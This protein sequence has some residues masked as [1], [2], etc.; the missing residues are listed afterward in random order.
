MIDKKNM[1]LTERQVLV[2]KLKKKGMSQA[3]IARKLKTT[4]G[5]ICTTEKL[6]LKNVEK[7]K[8]TLK[9][10]RTIESPVNLTIPEG[11]DLYDVPEMIFDIADKKQIKTTLDEAA[12]IVKLK[13]EAA[14]RLR[15]RLAIDNIDLSVDEHGNL[16]IL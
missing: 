12:I 10:Y 3:E 15:G 5:N 4:R 13:T 14:D 11:T 16:I 2:L 7:A 8:N 1:F 6:A 9:F